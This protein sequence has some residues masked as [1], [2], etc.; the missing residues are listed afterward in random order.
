[1][2]KIRKTCVLFI[3]MAILMGLSVSTAHAASKRIRKVKASSIVYTGSSADY[4]AVSFE[5]ERIKGVTG[6]QVR[7]IDKDSYDDHHVVK[8]YLN[9]SSLKRNIYIDLASISKGT[10][11]RVQVRAYKNKKG[12]LFFGKWSTSKRSFTVTFN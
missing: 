3:C 8:I 11:Y 4:K 7:L 2:K 10:S 12:R 9:A 6:Y 5:W 1:M